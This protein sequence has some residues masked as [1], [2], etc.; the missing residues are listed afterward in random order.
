MV[1]GKCEQK[2]SRQQSKIDGMERMEKNV[3]RVGGEK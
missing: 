2:N 1:N 3:W